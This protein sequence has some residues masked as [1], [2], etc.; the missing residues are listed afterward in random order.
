MK[1]S[2]LAETYENLEKISAKLEKTH[3]ISQLLKE[4]PREIL[5]KVVLLLNVLIFP[6]LSEEELGVANQL[7]IKSISKSYGI[8]DKEIIKLFNKTGDLGLTVEN[9]SKNK[10]QTVLG[11]KEL[12]VE[13]VFENLQL[14]AKQIGEGSQERKM[15]LISELLS[16]ANPKESKYI[17]RTVLGQ[18]RIGVAEGIIRDAIAEAF[19]V[20]SKSVEDAWFL[21]QDYGEIAKIAKDKGENGLKKLKIELGKPISVLLGE[22]SPTLKDALDSFEKLIIEFKYDGMRA[23]IHKDDDRIC[24]F[25]RRLENVTKQ[26]PDLVEL[27]KKCLIPKKCIVEGE[28]LAIDPKTKKPQPFQH[29]SQRIKRKYDIE[30]MIKKIPIQMNLFDIVYLNGESL[31]D[32]TLDERRKILKSITKEIPGKFQL[33]NALTTKDL[34]KAEDFYKLALSQGQEGVFVKNLEA[35]YQPGRRVAGG[36]LKVKPTLESL[37]LVIMGATWGTGKRAGWMGSFII[38]C[39]D[40]DT[41]KFLECGMLGTGV[42][43]KKTLP[44]DVTFNSLTK[45]LKPNIESEKGNEVKIKPKIANKLLLRFLEFMGEQLEQL[46]KENKD[47]KLK[48]PEKTF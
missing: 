1:Y 6:Y 20:S 47:I 41:G 24:I 40:A 14:I 8:N 37:D 29:L 30:E 36:W 46:Y 44:E 9:L 17:V 18:L 13:K 23:Q 21:N 5:P 16:Q 39:R 31:F 48:I 33:T 34:K 3:I 22:K 38:G 45:L 12:G 7:M 25:T 35:K 43:E 4:T 19:N 10:K 28:C 11:K 27:C 2:I 42:K 26:F 15:N 32:K